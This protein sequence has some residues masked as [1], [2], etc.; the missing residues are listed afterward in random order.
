[1]RA[2]ALLEEVRGR[3]ERFHSVVGE[4]LCRYCGQTLTAAHVKEEQTK[5]RK[6]L[7]EGE[8]THGR[9]LQDQ[10]SL[11]QTEKQVEMRHQA[12]TRLRDEAR[13][14]AIDCRRREEKALEAA[15]RHQETCAAAYAELTEPFRSQ[16]SPS[17]PED[18]LTT[19][20]PAREN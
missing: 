17:I 14:Q 6:E 3:W 1:T 16:V 20:F 9:A 8:A 11:R 4:K 15:A 7:A 5:I 10:A 12:A 19:V 13:Q 18:W 2:Q